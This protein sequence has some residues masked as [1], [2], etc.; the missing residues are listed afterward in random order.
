MWSLALMEE[1]RP[2]GFENRA[3][4]RIFGPKR[5]DVTG[6]WRKLHNEG[7]RDLYYSSS[8]IRMIKS[9]RMSWAGHVGRMG[10]RGTHLGYGSESQKERDH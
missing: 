7:L 5:D 3:L 6:Y 10:R 9:R 2:K 8:I 1:R 4:I